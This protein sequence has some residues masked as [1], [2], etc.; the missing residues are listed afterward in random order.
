MHKPWTKDGSKFR[1]ERIEADTSRPMFRELCV[2]MCQGRFTILFNFKYSYIHLFRWIRRRNV[3]RLTT[4]Q[5]ISSINKNKNILRQHSIN[6]LSL[7]SRHMKDYYVIT[8]IILSLLCVH[9]TAGESRYRTI[10]SLPWEGMT[11]LRM[12]KITMERPKLF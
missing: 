11:T 1:R 7:V 8:L 6:A 9:Y 5:E 4:L 10:I 3:Q 2:C 12:N